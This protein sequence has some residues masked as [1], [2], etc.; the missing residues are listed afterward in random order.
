MAVANTQP[1]ESALYYEFSHLYDLVFGRLFYPRIVRV[2]RSL[3]IEPGARVLEIGVGTGL[4]A[5][6]VSASLPGDRH[7]PGAGDARARAGPRE[8]QRLAARHPGAGRRP[9]PAVRQ[10]R[11]RLRD[12]LPRR[13]RGARSAAHDGRGAAR[14]PPRRPARRSSTTSAA[15]TGPSPACSAASIRSRAVSAG[16]P[17]SSPRFSIAPPCTSSG[18]GRRRRARCSRSS[19][20]ATRRQSRRRAGWRP[21]AA[22]SLSDRL[23]ISAGTSVPARRES[24]HAAR[25]GR[26]HARPACGASACRGAGCPRG[27]GT[28]PG[29]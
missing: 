13:E 26:P 1:H 24:P 6:G 27:G 25:A 8:P 19:S 7:R 14:L 12:G 29:R 4:V 15:R 20:R 11:V 9:Q 22:R 5:R 23:P 28:A 16:P 2:I 10:R 3:G 18:S 21:R 17:S